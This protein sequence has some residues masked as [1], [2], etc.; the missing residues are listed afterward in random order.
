MFG[1]FQNTPPYTGNGQPT[2]N[3]NEGVF[4]FL[5]GLFACA[6][7]PK[8]A[9]AEAG[10][11]TNP[12]PIFGLAPS[13]EPTSEQATQS[14]CAESATSDAMSDPLAA[15]PACSVPLPF[16]IVIQRPQ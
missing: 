13:T 4:G 12:G 9:T 11:S 6:G 8:Y 10:P 3:S 15:Q 5:S 2:A 1:L 14:E 7:T 16:A